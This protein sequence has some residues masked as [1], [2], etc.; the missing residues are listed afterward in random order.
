MG[1]KEILT[2]SWLRRISAQ[3]LVNSQTS[4][5][6]V[7]AASASCSSSNGEDMLNRRTTSPPYRA[8]SFPGSWVDGR[9]D[10]SAPGR[11]AFGGRPKTFSTAVSL[12]Q[13]TWGKT[14]RRLH[15]CGSMG[16]C[17]WGRPNWPLFP[18]E[19]VEVDVHGAAIAW[20]GAVARRS[21]RNRGRGDSDD[22]TGNG[23]MVLT[24]Q[25]HRADEG[26]DVYTALGGM[27]RSGGC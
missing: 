25:A 14:L 6:S 22:E 10:F 9:E 12:N 13:A 17:G 11:I 4:R 5:K 1:E 26:Q 7:S 8:S 18:V 15:D 2:S 16:C 20:S 19:V 23:C 21:S 27:K 3:L 24:A